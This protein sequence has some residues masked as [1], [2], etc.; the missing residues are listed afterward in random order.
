M[1]RPRLIPALLYRN[2][3]LVK[4]RKF[5]DFKYIGDPLNAV[6]ICI[7]DIWQI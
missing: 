3:G 4:T 7:I 1:I 5:K 2:K 6:K